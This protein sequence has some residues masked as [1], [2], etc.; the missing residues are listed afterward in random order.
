MMR[1]LRRQSDQTGA[2]GVNL[3]LVLAFALFAVIQL[4]RTTVAAGQIDDRVKKIRGEVGLVDEELPLDD[5]ARPDAVQGDDLV[6]RADARL[7]GRRTGRDSDDQRSGH[8]PRIGPRPLD[9]CRSTLVGPAAGS[10]EVRPR[11]SVAD[12]R[13]R[14]GVI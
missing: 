1:A 13:D 11:D 3:V 9:D 7:L 6:A 8:S 10:G 4:T 2:V 5:V 14:T 12:H